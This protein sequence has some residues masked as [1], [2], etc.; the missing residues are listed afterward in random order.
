MAKHYYA[1][2]DPLLSADEARGMVELC[3]RYGAYKMYSEEPTF[4]G[5]LGEG[6]PAR[7]DAA[8]NFLKTGGRFGAHESIETL[9]A[10]TN[11]FRE[12]YAYGDDVRITGI[13]PFLHHE[14]FR[15]AARELY[16]RPVIV[17]AIVYANLLVP[18]QELAVHSDVPEFRGA[19]RTKHPQWLLVA[20]HHSKLFD[21]WRMPI[22]TGVAWFHDC[23]GG[24]FAFYPEGPEGQP[25]AL[26]VR[27]NTA[28]LL[29]TDSVFHGVDRV[30]EKSRPIKP[31]LPGMKLRAAG[32]RRW[33]IVDNE[34]V[35]D[36]YDWS[37]LRFS[38]SWK[39]YCF[40]DER[41]R[42]AWHAHGDDL[43]VEFAV[44]RLLDDLRERGKV[45][46]RAPADHELI[47]LLIDEYIPY[48]PPQSVA[49][50]VRA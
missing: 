20:M 23:D 4:P 33:Q 24:E 15:R 16:D 10:R 3:H 2:F 29:D 27:F 47:N 50:A 34:G 17:P 12:S 25:V 35:V 13:E 19:N 26:G 22:A 32:G 40:A 42:A 44:A 37:D 18:G 6:L 28:V 46:T 38:I 14:G 43:T 11:Y 41:E 31:L 39:A 5:L 1:R 7:Y 45:S 9:A 49:G 30:A 36:E 48:P 21:D 8:R